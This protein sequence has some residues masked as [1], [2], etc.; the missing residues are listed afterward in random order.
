[1]V[2]K[3][4]I[5]ILILTHVSF[6]FFSQSIFDSLTYSVDSAL[7][8]LKVD[9]LNNKWYIYD[10]KIVRSSAEADLV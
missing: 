5:S 10:H 3:R 7:L 2:V 4:I 8:D 6:S 9:K 1:M